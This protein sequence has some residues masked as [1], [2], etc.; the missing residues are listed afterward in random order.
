MTEPERESRGGANRR[1][2]M[3]GYGEL[4]ERERPNR[5]GWREAERG[6]VEVGREKSQRLRKKQTERRTG[7]NTTPR[8]T[9]GTGEQGISIKAYTLG[10]AGLKSIFE[11]FQVQGLKMVITVLKQRSNNP[12]KNNNILESTEK[13]QQCNETQKK[14]PHSPCDGDSPIRKG[15]LISVWQ[16]NGKY[17]ALILV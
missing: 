17:A 7:A 12:R 8:S 1:Q 2:R 14:N 15:V 11:A 5:E 10:K 3:S 16:N 4:K 6:E 13:E 9:G